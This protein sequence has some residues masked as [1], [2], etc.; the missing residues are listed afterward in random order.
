MPRKL[1][2]IQYLS[3][4]SFKIKAVFLKKKLVNTLF[5]IEY[6]L[7]KI[8]LLMSTVNSI[9]LTLSMIN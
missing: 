3:T 2:S 7:M 8:Y 9:L 4:S 5:Q 6:V 1:A